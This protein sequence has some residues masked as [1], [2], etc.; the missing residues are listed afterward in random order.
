M[1]LMTLEH[2]N[3]KALLETIGK[4]QHELTKENSEI[5]D[6]AMKTIS[7][8]K[9]VS[10]PHKIISNCILYTIVPKDVTEPVIPFSNLDK[11]GETPFIPCR[12]LPQDETYGT[13]RMSKI[14]L[15]EIEVYKR[16]YEQKAKSP[17]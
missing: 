9:K 14:T 13:I 11:G 17:L 12:S 5:L 7:G 3:S 6:W 8:K 10:Q 4:R 16:K 15:E 1:R 2:I